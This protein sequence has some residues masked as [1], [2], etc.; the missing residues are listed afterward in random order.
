MGV[1]LDN[2]DTHIVQM[3]ASNSEN[4]KCKGFDTYY[5]E[6]FCSYLVEDAEENIDHVDGGDATDHGMHLYPTPSGGVA[7]LEVS[8]KGYRTLG[9]Y[10]EITDKSTSTLVSY[11]SW[12]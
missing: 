10:L 6:S 3:G 11:L 2:S 9:D 5:E 12:V 7:T 1:L 4:K 8:K